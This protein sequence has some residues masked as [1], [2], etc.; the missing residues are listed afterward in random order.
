[1]RIGRPDVAYQRSAL[2]E[3][4]ASWRQ[5]HL[6]VVPWLVVLCLLGV[7]DGG[8]SSDLVEMVVRLP[9]PDPQKL[10]E[11]VGDGVVTVERRS[12]GEGRHFLDDVEPLVVLL[13]I[14]VVGRRARGGGRGLDLK[15]RV[16]VLNLGVGRRHLE[17]PEGAGGRDEVVE[18]KKEEGCLDEV[19][20]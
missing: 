20:F 3:K 14:L 10:E 7:V 5:T 19:S 13:L 6:P 12:G 8:L 11:V 1:M 15:G 17:G 4:R 16:H 18:G 9:L 2:G